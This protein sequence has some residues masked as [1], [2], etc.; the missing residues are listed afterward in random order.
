MRLS[1]GYRIF[2][3]LIDGVVVERAREA[4]E[5]IC[6]MLRPGDGR[7]ERHVFPLGELKAHRNPGVSA[8]VVAGK[9]FL[10]SHLPELGA[11]L[12]ELVMA[13]G[14]WA[15]A[16]EILETEEVV[17]H[18]S[19]VTRKPAV[20][21]PNL[22]WHR[23]YPNGYVCPRRSEDFFRFLIPLEGMDEENGCT[24]AV[25]GTEEIS[26][27]VA[28]TEPREWEESRVVALRV[29]AGGAVAIHPKVLHGGRENRSSRNRNVVVMQFGRVTADFL[30]DLGREEREGFLRGGG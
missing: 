11:E 2:E 28:L 13:P 15:A 23:D 4:V 10:L 3:G 21:G 20:V 24:L 26:D 29:R 9:A 1:G 25:P 16:R 7:W 6:A 5:A 12:R 8:E 19:N 27:E 18:F 30:H 22:S 14:V 17:C